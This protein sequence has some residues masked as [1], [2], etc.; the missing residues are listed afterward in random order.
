MYDLD[1][2]NYDLPKKFIAQTPAEKRDHSRLMVLNQ[3]TQSIEHDQFFNITKYLK[4]G[5]LLVFNNS[6]V[7]P[8]RILGHKKTG[9]SVEVL[10]LKDLGSDQWECLVRPGKRLKIGT[11]IIFN[12]KLLKAAVVDE[13][14]FGG[15][16]LQFKYDG[17]FNEILDQ[18]GL[19][20]LPPYIDTNKEVDVKHF[21]AERYQTVYAEVA[22]SAAAPTAG[23]HFTPELLTKLKEQGIAQAFVTLHTGLGTFRPVDSADIREHKMHSE[24]FEIAAE[25]LQKIRQ[26]KKAGGRVIAVGTT[27]IRVLESVKDQ[28]LDD[29]HQ[30]AISGETNIF[31]FPSYQFSVVDGLVTNFHL[32]KSSLL[33]LVSA[34]AGRDFVMQ[35]YEEAKKN[36]YRFFSFGDAMLIV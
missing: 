21:L 20:P 27:S 16:I 23:L 19:I 6:K 33:M 2:Y 24:W 9:G 18:V 15:R 17:I 26:T 35:A 30:T 28:I 7:I 10:L 31:I 32:P 3:E 36:S 29:D 34:L 22:G 4:S 25:T 13:T 12:D 8:A 1:L 11:E 5:D 14:D